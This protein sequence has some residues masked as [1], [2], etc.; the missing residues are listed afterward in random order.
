M[1]DVLE[2]AERY[3]GEGLFEEAIGQ[4]RRLIEDGQADCTTYIRCAT[5]HRE[6]GRPAEARVVFEAAIARF[7]DDPWPRHR[8]GELFGQNGRPAAALRRMREARDLAPHGEE[9]HVNISATAAGLGWLDEAYAAARTLRPEVGDWWAGAR[10]RGLEAYREERSA[11]LALLRHRP[12]PVTD[13]LLSDLGPRLVRLGRLR[14]A[15]RIAST[16]IA[17]DPSSAVAHDMMVNLVLRRDGADAAFAY[18]R[19]TPAMQADPSAYTVRLA[20]L[21]HE[22]G[23]Y[24]EILEA[25]DAPGLPQDDEQLRWLRFMALLLLGW[26]DRLREDCS[27]WLAA[28]PFAMTPSATLAALR[29][30]AQ[31]PM[32]WKGGQTTLLKPHIA[33]F[34]DKPDVPRDVRG[35]MLSWTRLNPQ[36]AYTL[37]DDASARRFLETHYGSAIVQLYDAC[38]H[39]AMKADY[40]R[41]AF[42]HQAGGLY[43]DADELCLRPLGYILDAAEDA[44]IIA[45]LDG[46]TPGYVH[47]A[48]LGGRPRSRLVRWALEQATE[49]VAHELQA[50]RRP[51]IWSLTGPGLITRAIGHYLATT[52]A[53]WEREEMLL[54]GRQQY[55]WFAQ[56]DGQ[57]AYK[58]DAAKNWNMI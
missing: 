28:S 7:P 10:R 31:T 55:G 2:L 36:V 53:A 26:T 35:V 20:R 3:E 17:R 47:N 9:F 46:D 18:M 45:M 24:A 40:F 32:P 33:Q 1:P 51:D 14:L 16:L 6:R 29:H 56:K 8:L 57:L 22:A 43:A 44:E 58:H 11:T 49:L 30:Q 5:L 54:L 13:A 12:K 37:F 52:P 25:L 50:G 48:F 34:W 19:A 15:E 41:I 23:R 38:H 21:L 27:R 42:L 4:Y 39:P